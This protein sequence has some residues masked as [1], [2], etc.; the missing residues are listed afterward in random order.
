MIESIGWIG[1]LLLSTC[2]VPLVIDVCV[3]K[4]VES[5]SKLFLLWWLLGEILLLIYIL[6]LPTLSIPLLFNYGFNCVC[7][8]LV[9]AFMTIFNKKVT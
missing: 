4:K 9:F 1:S 3:K 6:A 8:I 2:G 5:V 7:L